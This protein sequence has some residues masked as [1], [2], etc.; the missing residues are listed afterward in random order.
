MRRFR[1]HPVRRLRHGLAQWRAPWRAQW[2]AQWRTAWL[3]LWLAWLLVGLGRLLAM[4]V[5]ALWIPSM[6]PTAAPM[7]QPTAHQAEPTAATASAHGAHTRLACLSYAPF[8]RDG[9]S[10]MDPQL[11]LTDQQLSEDLSLLARW[12]GC[13]RTYGTAHGQ[14]RIPALAEPLGLKVV[15][16]AWIS[17]DRAAN[18][19]EV[20]KALALAR[21][22][23]GTVR[24]L[25]LGNEVLLRQEIS[26]QELAALL[27]DARQRS[28]VPVAYADVWEFWLRNAAVLAPEVDM[29]AA[30]LLPYWEDEPIGLDAAV[31][32][33]LA[34]HRELVRAF[35]GKPVWIAET[36]WPWAG[37]QRGPALPGPREQA[38][39]V[40]ELR[41]RLQAQGIDYNL[42]E[43]FDQPWKRQFEG[44]MGGAWGVADAS[45]R[46]R[47]PGFGPL[48]VDPIAVGVWWGAA[49][50]LL[51]SAS[52]AFI[53]RLGHRPRGGPPPLTCAPGDGRWLDSKV[54]CCTWPTLLCAGTTMGLLLGAHAYTMPIWLRSPVEWGVAL[55]QIGLAGTVCLYS[56]AMLVWASRRV[57]NALLL[58]FLL[59][60]AWQALTIIFDG[61]YRPLP[62]LLAAAPAIG[63]WLARTHGCGMPRHAS[64]RVLAAVLAVASPVLL[65]LEGWANAQAWALA[66]SWCM[67]A[68]AA[69]GVPGTAQ[70]LHGASGSQVRAGS[71]GS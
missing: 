33:V 61:R 32:H 23:P 67:T 46:L 70:V 63:L 31:D 47:D 43:A 57:P 28:P 11:R 20:E 45:G 24:L 35:A 7:A 38:A 66:C 6:A 18:Q 49:V 54:M 14:D 42:I 22:H 50:G 59:V 55:V 34:V 60:T 16:G 26:P 13:I 1:T 52:L 30:H 62:A 71:L 17:R 56:L 51:A 29:V 25:I 12:T 37:R 3:S 40:R 65:V 44:A 69:W 10:P 19:Q 2:R 68:L 48:P 41:G 27:R 15:Q 4:Q 36:G 53:H 64:T 5:D 39:F 58:G 21:A 8:R 9:H